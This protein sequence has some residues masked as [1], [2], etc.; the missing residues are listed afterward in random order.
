M[1]TGEKWRAY[2][3]EPLIAILIESLLL[4]WR[5]APANAQFM[6]SE[7]RDI[8]SLLLVLLSASLALWIGLF[9]VSSTEFGQWLSKRG[10]LNPINNAFV[11]TIIILV[12]S[13][14][15]SIICAFA[16]GGYV[17]VM[18]VGELFSILSLVSVPGMLMNTSGLLKLHSLFAVLKSG[19]IEPIRQAPNSSDLQVR[20]R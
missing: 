5:G 14:V 8:L 12:L 6:H 17:K 7:A 1:T 10:E 13:C 11:S 15:V 4:N 9:W 2:L 18:L 3:P 19:E 16:D 20:K